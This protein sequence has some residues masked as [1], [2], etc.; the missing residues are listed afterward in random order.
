MGVPEFEATKY[1]FELTSPIEAEDE[2]PKAKKA[3]PGK[4]PV[5][6]SEEGEGNENKISIDNAVE[7][8]SKKIV[9]FKMTVIHQAPAYEDPNP[10]E[11]DLTATKKGKGAN[12]EPEVRM[13]TPDPVVMV[14]EQ[15][16]EF[17]IEIGRIEDVKI[18]TAPPSYNAQEKSS[19]A[20][21]GGASKVSGEP[22]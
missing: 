20:L 15:G 7:D 11:E 16:R 1:N 19:G 9:G 10:P 14:N 12:A 18:E 2:D 3:P 4:P 8:E 6:T 13:I 21:D 22:T 5:P 17:E